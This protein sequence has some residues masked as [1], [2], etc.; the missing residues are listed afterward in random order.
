MKNT[1]KLLWP[2]L[3]VV[4]SLLLLWLAVRNIDWQALRSTNIEIQPF[5]FVLALALLVSANLL[6]VVRWG[7]LLRSLGLYHPVSNYVTLYFA[8]GLINQGLPSTVG[9]DSYR[10]VEASRL[11]HNA[12]A[13]AAQPTLTQELHEP[14]DLQ[15]APPR[16]RLGFLSVAL[17]RGL[18]LVGNNILGALGL[19]LSGSMIAP[20]GPTLGAWVLGVMLGGAA[21]G[22]LLL[23]LQRTRGLILALLTKLGMSQA[24]KGVDTAFGWPQVALQL[25]ISVMTHTLAL[26]AFWFCLRAF[27]IYAPFAALMVGLPALGLLMMLPISISGWGL[28]EATLSAA[29]VLWGVDGGVTVLASVSF[30][31]VT[32]V[33]YL[34]GAV[35]LL[36][37]R[38][39]EASSS[40][41]H[42]TP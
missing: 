35:S 19:L 16:L 27:G 3:R 6:A 15:R 28:R 4:L 9:G 7:W 8:G 36:R 25:T 5:W 26:C 30:G 31:I 42:A 41:Q 38:R 2:Y 12:D 1:F 33:T 29:L 14:I 39:S 34:P 10:A 24:L 13:S 11:A 21:V 17:D 20:W 23:K 18:G 22:C 37:R 40:R 32:L